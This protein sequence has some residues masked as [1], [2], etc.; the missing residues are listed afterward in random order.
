[1]THGP[2]TPEIIWDCKLKAVNPPF[3][4]V[5][6]PRGRKDLRVVGRVN[7]DAC[8][9]T[10][11][12]HLDLWD[13]NARRRAKRLEAEPSRDAWQ[14]LSALATNRGSTVAQLLEQTFSEGQ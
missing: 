12:L 11:R 9:R 13:W 1:M 10:P 4:S 14:R 2:K 8:A 3:R 5:S 6:T 7:P